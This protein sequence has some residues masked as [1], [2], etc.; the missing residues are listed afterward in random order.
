MDEQMND[1]MWAVDDA[2]A[3]LGVKP[4]TVHS[5]RRRGGTFPEPDGY[6]GTT[7]WWKPERVIAWRDARPSRNR[8]PK[9]RPTYRWET[10]PGRPQ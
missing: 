5:Y 3:F 1:A 8:P 9:K 10:L 4:T 2:A 7:P 6:V